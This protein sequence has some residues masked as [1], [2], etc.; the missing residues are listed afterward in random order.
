MLMKYF[1]CLILLLMIFI[2]ENST[3]A[4]EK[5]WSN[6]IKTENK[7]RYLKVLGADS[8]NTFV[9]RSNQSFTNFDW[10]T[11]KL[12]LLTFNENMKVISETDLQTNDTMKVVDVVIVQDHLMILSLSYQKNMKMLRSFAYNIDAAGKIISEIVPLDFFESNKID[13]DNHPELI[14]SKNKNYFSYVMYQV[15]NKNEN[16]YRVV[17]FDQ[18]LK[19]T[20]TTSISVQDNKRYFYIQEMAVSNEGEF[21]ML[22]QHGKSSK[23]IKSPDEL[24]YEVYSIDKN[25]LQKK[26]FAVKA[27]NKFISDAGL[28]IDNRNNKIVVA[29]F[30]SLINEFSIAGAFVY[31]HG[32]DDS[33]AKVTTVPLTGSLL[34]SV[35]SKN[36]D[37]EIEDY[38]IDRIILRND[39]GAVIV[40]ESNR[41]FTQSY[42][43]YYTQSYVYK[44]YYYYG[45]VITLSLNPDG[46]ILWDEV[47][48]KDQKSV[49]DDGFYS[50]Y[51]FAFNGKKIYYFYNK[52]IDARSAVLQSAVNTQG[53]DKNETALAEEENAYLLPQWGKQINNDEIVVPVSKEGKLYIVKMP[54]E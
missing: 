28:S 34:G 7:L 53:A 21:Y 9:L 41:I 19:K 3:H 36:N 35:S 42:W 20:F 6:E 43:D 12:F 22:A 1:Q 14:F 30:Y 48:K 5:V 13:F 40:A 47:I 38:S 33:S 46:S 27:E 39:G 24:L 2:F 18:L 52:Y 31:T 44:R 17:M 45:N 23:R 49:D 51:T 15:M 37:N 8:T 50:S 4:A 16:V 32:S 25:G 10:R 26:T 54:L 29:G 11:R